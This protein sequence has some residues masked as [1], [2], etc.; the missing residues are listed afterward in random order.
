MHIYKEIGGHT[1]SVGG[2]GA[3]PHISGW[4]GGKAEA[5]EEQGGGRA[6][7]PVE[8]PFLSG[9]KAGILIEVNYG[10][11]VFSVDSRGSCIASLID[12]SFVSC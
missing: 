10:L 1:L 11:N 6:P 12:Y 3:R 8:R 7:L 4:R 5:A 9:L 2:R